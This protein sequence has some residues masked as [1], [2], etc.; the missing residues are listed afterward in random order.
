MTLLA[1]FP[2]R[3]GPICTGGGSSL[4]SARAPPPKRRQASQRSWLR[5]IIYHW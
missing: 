5:E 1:D 2:A 3:A 4:I